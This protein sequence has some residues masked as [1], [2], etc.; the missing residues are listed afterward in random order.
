MG[1]LT[2]LAGRVV[3]VLTVRETNFRKEACCMFLVIH[4][5]YHPFGVS[6]VI[7]ALN[8]SGFFLLFTSCRKEGEFY[9]QLKDCLPF[10]SFIVFKY[11][12]PN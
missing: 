8:S 7:A 6:V 3:A 1:R 5:I 9:Y 11:D 4:V 10:V 12:V 2:S